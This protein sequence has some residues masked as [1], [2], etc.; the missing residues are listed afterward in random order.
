[1]VCA[2]VI[3]FCLGLTTAIHRRET[4]RA[5]HEARR[6]T[7]A[8][9]G[10]PGGLMLVAKDRYLLLLAVLALVLNAVNTTGEYLLDRTL[11]D[12]LAGS[13]P[14]ELKQAIG[15]FK[16]DF[17]FWVNG[18][19]LGLQLFVVSRVLGHAG[20]RAALFVLPVVALV[21]YGSLAA[22]PALAWFSRVKIAE[23]S[24]DYSLQNTA[25][26]A[27]FLPVSKSAKYKAK[28]VI[29]GFVVRFGDVLSAAAV[30]VGASVGLSV[31]G[32]ALFNVTLT[33]VWLGVV[34]LLSRAHARLPHSGEAGKVASA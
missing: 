13:S 3:V 25:R 22:A 9:I 21:G 20:V 28:A 31:R 1:L 10:G 29:D 24:L 33:V 30:G 23:N 12:S 27:L 2:A 7:D 11:L 17:F 34:A 26:Q 18:V 4:S 32:F 14:A 6:A 16:A 8:P 15:A 5:P 19:S